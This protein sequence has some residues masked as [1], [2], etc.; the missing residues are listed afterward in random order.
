MLVC[1]ARDI[2]FH[3][4]LLRLRWRRCAHSILRVQSALKFHLISCQNW[5]WRGENSEEFELIFEDVGRSVYTWS[6]GCSCF[7]AEKLVCEDQPLQKCLEYMALMHSFLAGIVRFSQTSTHSVWRYP[8]LLFLPFLQGACDRHHRQGEWNSVSQ[9]FLFDELGLRDGT[10]GGERAMFCKAGRIIY[11]R[12]QFA[13]EMSCTVNSYWK[14]WGERMSISYLERLNGSISKMIC[15]LRPLRHQNQNIVCSIFLDTI[16][17][18]WQAFP[19]PSI[20][21]LWPLSAFV[22]DF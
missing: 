14:S 10:S 4:W 3:A 20:S 18:H 22:Q 6:R 17:K 13:N 12:P 7:A 19:K 9:L 15:P 5:S 8:I 11:C 21:Q 2:T 16:A 1:A